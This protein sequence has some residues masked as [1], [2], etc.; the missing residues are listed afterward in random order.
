VRGRISLAGLPLVGAS[1]AT[2]PPAAAYSGIALSAPR[3][4]IDGSGKQPA[5]FAVVRVDDVLGCPDP[6]SICTFVQF[7]LFFNPTG[8]GNRGIAIGSGPPPPADDVTSTA[9]GSC[10]IPGSQSY[11][12]WFEQSIFRTGDRTT[13]LDPRFRFAEHDCEQ[14]SNEI[15][16]VILPK[17]TG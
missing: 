17:R 9:V 4:G 3:L 14:A 16:D 10:V 13:R 15:K 11:T 1:L 6:A 5:L 12:S 2:P 7:A 8:A